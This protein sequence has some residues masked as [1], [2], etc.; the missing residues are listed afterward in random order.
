MLIQFNF[1]N[2]KSFREEATL[3]LSAA[4]MT[5]FSD[6]VVS[7]GSEKIL[8]VAA[9]YGANA[10]GK[11]NIYNAFE[12]MTDYV[13]DSFK[14]GDEEEKFEYF[15]PTPF[16]F[17]TTSANAESS[18]EVY[19]TLPGDK[20]EK[21]YNYGFCI[22][23]EGVTEEWLNSKAKTARKYSPV[24][25]RNAEELDLSGFPKSRT[26]AILYPLGRARC[27]FSLRL[28]FRTWTAKPHQQ[29]PRSKL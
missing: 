9:I 17:D 6:R 26:A 14:Y 12:Y 10:S 29:V 21:T 23:K 3:D 11:S 20:A 28:C 19:F 2:F 18:F 4:K 13:V 24:F 5:E 1:K 25:Y 27:F 8:P 7:I 22:D 16:L 15:R